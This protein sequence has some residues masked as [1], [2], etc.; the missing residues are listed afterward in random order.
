MKPK[1]LYHMALSMI[2]FFL[3][4]FILQ[5]TKSLLAPFH[6]EYYFG[7]HAYKLSLRENIDDP[8]SK[9]DS[10]AFIGTILEL[11]ESGATILMVNQDL[12]GFGYS[13]NGVDLAGIK[14]QTPM[15]KTAMAK[16]NMNEVNY[17]PIRNDLDCF[18]DHFIS[19]DRDISAQL[20]DLVSF[21]SSADR[22]ELIFS[23][24]SAIKFQRL[25]SPL[26]L[27]YL[28]IYCFVIF[29]YSL[30]IN[31]KIW[32]LDTIISAHYL[33]GARKNLFARLYIKQLSPYLAAGDC[34]GLLLYCF[35]LFNTM[36]PPTKAVLLL[37]SHQ[38]SDHFRCQL[39][40]HRQ[41]L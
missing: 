16:T 24:E 5:M 40:C 27:L 10:A 32:G 41:G 19:S 8:P 14:H 38:H 11:T 30:I 18:A 9:D 4:L 26:Y 37:V 35:S 29:T 28:E 7:S 12:P 15:D 33:S 17:Y 21:Y 31:T 1:Y 22:F 13:T 36:Q 3:T 6:P 20:K 25:A 39:S 2:L 23:D 34:L